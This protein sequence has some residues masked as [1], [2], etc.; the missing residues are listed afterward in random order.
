MSLDTAPIVTA[1]SAPAEE[2]SFTWRYRYKL[3]PQCR[4]QCPAEW[5]PTDPNFEFMLVIWPHNESNRKAGY[6][7]GL[8]PDKFR[9]LK[10]KF[11]TMP[12]GD[13]KTDA[14]RRAIFGNTLK[15]KLD[16]SGRFCLPRDMCTAVGLEKE[17]HFDGNG[18]QFGIWNPQTFDQCVDIEAPLTVD[19][20]NLI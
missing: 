13:N 3:D 6:I 20:F 17:V 12:M 2:M 14:L 8:T 10:A 4:V 16:P 7:K 9:A 15:T 19:A 11:L 5:R 1:P 18:D